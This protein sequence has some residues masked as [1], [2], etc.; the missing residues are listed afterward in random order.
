[1]DGK[2]FVDFDVLAGLDA[3]AAENALVRVVAIK[4]IGV[5]DFVRLGLKRILWC[6]TASIFVVLW[7]VQLPLLLSQTV[8]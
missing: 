2:R 6:S 7:T 1:M 4:R 3:A 8:Q 5:V